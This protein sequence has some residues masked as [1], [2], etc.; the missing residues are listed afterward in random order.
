MCGVLMCFSAEDLVD[1][2]GGHAVKIPLFMAVI[3]S[4]VS[5]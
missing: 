2:S 5:M 1:A 4:T 3:M